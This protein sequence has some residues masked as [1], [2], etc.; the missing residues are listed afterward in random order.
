MSAVRMGRRA[1]ARSRGGA[2]AGLVT[3]ASDLSVTS[4]RLG[5]VLGVLRYVSTD[6]SH[7]LVG[8][9]GCVKLA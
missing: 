2:V 1:G 3:R 4:R 6:C 5:R 9:S 8:V 7:L